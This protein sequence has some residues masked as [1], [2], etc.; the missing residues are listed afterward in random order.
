LQRSTSRVFALLLLLCCSGTQCVQPS[1]PVFPGLSPGAPR[2]LPEAPSKRQIIDVINQNSARVGSY[3]TNNATI[4]ISGLPTTF[5]AKIALEQPRRF[6]LKA[7]T[8]LTGPELDLGSND[9]L[10]WL[11]VR[12]GH[13]AAVYFCRHDQYAAGA[14]RQAVPVAPQWLIDALGLPRFGPEA[15]HSGPYQRPDGTL[16]IRSRWAMPQGDLIKITV[17]EEARGSVLQQHL[18][19]ADGKHLATAIAEDHQYDPATGVSLPSQVE[20]HMPPVGLSL[21]IDVGDYVINQPVGDRRQMWSRPSYAGFAEVDLATAP[22]PTAWS[23]AP[24]PASAR[25]ASPTGQESRR[26]WNPFRRRNY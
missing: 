22:P 11:W 25:R 16:E 12:R 23:M 13:P 8:G 4:T 6:R 19:T 15:V 1:W 7:G 2:L 17:V 14:A 21:K 18:L 10:F 24:P 3:A 5:R 26:Q 9:E 20:V